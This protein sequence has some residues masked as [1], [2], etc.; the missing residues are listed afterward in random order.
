M[1]GCPALFTVILVES[2]PF[3]RLCKYAVFQPWDVVVQLKHTGS[4][5]LR[6]RVFTVPKVF[7]SVIRGYNLRVVDLQCSSLPLFGSKTWLGVRETSSQSNLRRAASQRHHW[8]QWDA[9]NS[10]PKLPLLFD[11]HHPVYY[12]HSST[13][14]THHPKRHLDPFSRFATIHFADRPTDRWSR[15]MFRNMSRLR[16]LD[17]SDAAKNSSKTMKDT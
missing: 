3:H 2:T 8:L 16:S 13:D 10:P 1:Y 6:S 11:D 15:R 7:T 12:T 14:P 9:P 5:T 17:S 4:V